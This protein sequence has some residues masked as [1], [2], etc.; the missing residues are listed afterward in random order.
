MV[1]TAKLRLEPT[2]NAEAVRARVEAAV[3]DTFDPRA[4]ARDLI[5]TT[6]RSSRPEPEIPLTDG[7]RGVDCMVDSQYLY[8][9]L[10][11][12]PIG[13][14]PVVERVEIVESQ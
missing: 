9:R 2:A 4:H 3:R 12:L 8:D 10:G 5:R 11:Q 7:L 1:V 13:A 6:Y 14:V